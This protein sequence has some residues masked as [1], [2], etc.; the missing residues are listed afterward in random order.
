M[1]HPTDVPRP[2]PSFWTSV[3]AAA[4]AGVW[5]VGMVAGCGT[6]GAE[7]SA[8]SRAELFRE[9]A[10]DSTGVTFA[11]RLAESAD[12]NILNYLYYYNGGGVA[13]GDVNGDDRPDLYFTSN[14]DDNALYL[15]RGNFRF[16]EVTDAAGVAG[17]GDWTTGVSMADVN[18]DGR[19][20]LYVSVVSQF[21]GLSGHNQLFINQ[22]T[23]D[24][25][26]PVF[27]E[28]SAAYGLDHRGFS[29]QAAFF[30]YDRDGDLD[31]YLLN[32][33]VHST[34]TYG[35]VSMR[36]ERD[37]LSGDKLYENRG[38]TFVDVTEEAGI[39]GSTIGY[40]LGVVVSDVDV[41]GCPDLY[42]ANDFHE[43]DY[44]YL[45]NCDGTFT[46]TIETSTGH[47]SHSSM[48][49]DA[50]DINN[51]G[52]PDVAVLDM[53]P[54]R[55]EIVKTS[56]TAESYDV[57]QIQV[58]YGYHHQYAR[59]TLQLNQGVRPGGERAVPRFSDVGF[60]A[61][62]AATDWSWAPLFADF[63]LDG[64][65]DLFVSNGIYRRPNDLD[66]INYV[67]NREIQQSLQEITK[68]NLSL[69]KR[70][71]QV[72]I[73]NAAF[74]NAGDLRFEEA[75]AAW[76]LDH[77]GFSNGA[78]Y[79][80]LDGDGDLDLVTNNIGEPASIFENRADTLRDGRYLTVSLRGEGANTDGIGARVTATSGGTT[81]MREQVLTRGY[82]SSVQ[83]GLHFGFAET[84]TVD[85]LTV[86]WPDGRVQTRT[87]VATNQRVTLH[88]KDARPPEP[89]RSPTEPET[90]ADPV[91]ADGGT[92]AERGLDFRHRENDFLD[93]NREHLIPH[94]VSTEGP[95]LA[96]GDVNG[97]GREDVFAGG[98]K[99]QSAQLYLQQPGGRFARA[100]STVWTKDAKR[101]DVDAAFFDA[102]GD[103]DLDLYVV[104]AGAEFWGT[105][106]ALRDRLYLND[107]SGT[108]RKAEG[109]LPEENP[110]VTGNGGTVTPADYDGDGDVDLFVGG[111]VVAREYGETPASALLEN[112]GS[113]TFTDVTDRVAPALR[114]AGMVTDAA[115]LDA[116]GDDR[117]DLA[118]AGTWMPIRLFA[119]QPDGTFAEATCEAGLAE[120]GGWWNAVTAADVDGDG[121]DDLV[122][123]NL[124][125]NATLHATPDEPAR[126]YRN[127]F[128]DNGDEEVILTYYRDGIAYPMLG[129]DMLARQIESLKRK[130]PSYKE[131]AGKQIDDL[132]AE[133]KVAAA[134]MKEAHTFASVAAINDGGT[135]AVR[136]LPSRAQMA[137]LFDAA[138][139][140]WTG[141]GRPDVV[142]AGN[143]HGVRP[144]QGRYDASYGTLLRGAPGEGAGS[145]ADSL[146]FTAV[147]PAESGLWVDGQA[148]A[149][150]PLT[151]DGTRYLLIARNDAPLQLVRH[152]VEAPEAMAAR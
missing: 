147:P 31:L 62:V 73:P 100:D 64:R 103:G 143:F 18:G 50:G 98:A 108:F 126:L 5:L 6:G 19:L 88:Q 89:G 86:R 135:F 43:N 106:D 69:L 84:D 49:V 145:E 60:Q 111:R 120:T 140:D 83:P 139:L 24:D 29:T 125:L 92:A 45:N 127:D 115:F 17:T 80:D 22:G 150:A 59:N 112:D 107:G 10:A 90:G 101:E 7:T 114:E 66:Y 129:R 54:R 96:V 105:A 119:Q 57:R 44:L 91:F 131:F 2:L 76:G 151:I 142:M 14:E 41:D 13:V 71:P 51:D 121:D 42:V 55:E 75:A 104:S 37:S 61:G 144:V 56:V 15:N 34:K 21:E 48:G 26:V 93:W 99:W 53:L 46:E 32:H 85:T 1:Q 77:E 20:D 117:L 47:N 27:A 70:M 87:G 133:D 52:R 97:D 67:S 138:V 35:R 152:R 23:N 118:V 109:A 122:A 28:K 11:N 124:G 72:R 141:D 68:D 149:L 110:A 148:R 123:G 39:I 132:F 4:L 38:G 3:L 137:P 63:N 8:P 40:G 136:P 78:A 81:Q 33:A 58:D 82:Q 95:A 30:D 74:R 134:T 102:D 130:Y 128:D 113:G 94:K 9:H 79:G 65:Q 25:G 16:E 116:T 146:T 36:T 12:L